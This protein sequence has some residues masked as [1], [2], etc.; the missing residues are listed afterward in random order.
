MDSSPQKAD[1]LLIMGH[2]PKI[3]GEF[4]VIAENSVFSPFPSNICC[5]SPPLTFEGNPWDHN[6]CI[7]PKLMP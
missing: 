2:F 7:Q 6:V 3:L 5:P 1:T 4:S